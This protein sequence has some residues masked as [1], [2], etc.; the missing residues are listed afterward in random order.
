PF[1]TVCHYEPLQNACQAIF[2]IFFF[3]QNPQMLSLS[4]LVRI[5]R[6]PH[7]ATVFGLGRCCNEANPDKH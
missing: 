1:R 3:K 5:I 6:L 4:D 7:P 2:G